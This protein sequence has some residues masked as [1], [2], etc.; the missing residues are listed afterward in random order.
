[1]Q[2]PHHVLGI[3]RGVSNPRRHS[4]REFRGIACLGG[5]SLLAPKL[6]ENPVRD[7]LQ[8]PEQCGC[9]TSSHYLDEGCC[10]A[11][12]GQNAMLLRTS[13]TNMAN[14]FSRSS[15]SFSRASVHISILKLGGAPCYIRLPVFLNLPLDLRF[16]GLQP[17]VACNPPNRDMWTST[18]LLRYVS[19]SA[20]LHAESRTATS[21][22]NEMAICSS[23]AFTP[24]TA[25][26]SWDEGLGF[27]V[28]TWGV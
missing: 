26:N 11:N 14:R 7:V 28:W 10:P 25:H 8:T 3:L 4:L 6:L 20:P 1:M 16:Q 27:R 13:I 9:G 2:D 22:P 18:E 23:R 19:T 15:I 21:I 24:A 17:S 5:T 12:M